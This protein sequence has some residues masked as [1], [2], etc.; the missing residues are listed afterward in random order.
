MI[1][2][3]YIV[4]ALSILALVAC[5][6]EAPIAPETTG[7]SF[8][9]FA[10]ITKTTLNG[11]EVNWEN[12]DILYLVTSDGTWGK[13]SSDDNSGATIADFTYDGTKF[14]ST[15]TIEDGSYT[16]R[17]IYADES[18]RKYHR[19]AAT[20]HN[21]QKVQAQDCSAPTAHIKSNDALVGKFDATTPLTAGAA[22][23]M[24]HIYAIMKVDIKNSTAADAT[25]KSFTMNAEG[26]NLAGIFT[27]NYANTP[28]DITLK[29]NGSS[30]ITVNLTNGTVAKD[31]TLPVYF[32]M[33]PLADYTGEITLSV[34]DSDD[35]VYTTTKAVNSLTFAP[36][37][38]NKTGFT[39]S[40]ANL[41][42]NT[43]TAY[44]TATFEED[45]GHRTSGSNSYNATEKTYTTS[46]VSWTLKYADSVTSGSP[47]EGSANILTRIAASTTN[48]PTAITGNI[49]N[50]A[51]TVKKVSFLSKLGSTASVK[52]Y[53]STNGSDWTE[54]T[55]NKDVSYDATYGYSAEMSVASGAFYLKFEWS[56]TSTSKVDSQLD[57]ITV[58]TE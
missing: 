13:P 15:Q 3:K 56:R 18:Q 36:G 53:Y 41:V 29:Q 58:F 40:D 22:V 52:L 39:I 9:L 10:N 12:G 33:A 51:K 38:L 14:S 31:A 26:A 11:K 37:T 45:S 20:T 7:S 46:G 27:V 1:M 4:S 32:V 25:I 30:S 21:L 47:L 2:K 23:A 6:K 5:Q 57:K 55:F 28:I 50:E 19:G 49:L 8:D 44:Y 16:F 35:N 42:V 34:T 48:M 54:A 43:L 24:S 17:A